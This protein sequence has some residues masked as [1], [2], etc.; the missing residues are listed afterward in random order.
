MSATETA[1]IERRK[2]V[3]KTYV[4]ADIK[5]MILSACHKNPFTAITMEAD[6][7]KDFQKWLTTS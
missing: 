4:P 5:A 6:D 2:K 7:F 1:Q 3:T